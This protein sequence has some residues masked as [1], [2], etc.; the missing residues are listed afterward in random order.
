[1]AVSGCPTDLKGCFVGF[2]FS[3]EE[4][5]SLPS[6]PVSPGVTRKRPASSRDLAAPAWGRVG[7]GVSHVPSLL[8][9]GTTRKTGWPFLGSRWG[10]D[11]SCIFW[12]RLK[13]AQ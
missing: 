13:F 5:N 1:M 6:W 8:R 12:A 4:R 9:T 7:R 3:R 2:S 11:M 10:R